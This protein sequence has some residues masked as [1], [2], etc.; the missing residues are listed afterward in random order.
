M[1]TAA[2]FY[3]I[4]VAEN[5]SEQVAGPKVLMD[6]CDTGVPFDWPPSAQ[7]ASMCDGNAYDWIPGMSWYPF[8]T[9]SIK[10]RL[11]PI[12]GASIQWHGPFLVRGKSYYLLNCI[13]VVDCALPKSNSNQ[14]FV[15]ANNAGTS[16]IFRPK[17]FV[18]WLICSQ[19]FRD[20]CVNHGDT[21][22]RFGR[23]KEDGWEELPF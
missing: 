13:N 10:L 22:I 2:T 12:V 3:R 19:A 1:I 16:P 9:E 7:V 4:W 20:N 11:E 14:L 8:V 5:D 6:Q 21:G 18:R 15:D 17:G 23:I